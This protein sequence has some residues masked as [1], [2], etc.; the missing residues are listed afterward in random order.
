M[1]D[2]ST[3]GKMSKCRPM[4]EPTPVVVADVVVGIRVFIFDA[5]ISPQGMAFDVPGQSFH[6]SCVVTQ[7][8]SSNHG[9]P[10][11]TRSV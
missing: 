1:A 9:K 4:N 11:S 10:A 5:I 7:L 6:L 2:T 8:A 3:F